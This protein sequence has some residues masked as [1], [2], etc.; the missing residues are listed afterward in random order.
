MQGLHEQ[1]PQFSWNTNAGYPTK[2]HRAAIA[3]HGATVHHR[4]SFRLLSEGRQ[5]TLF[6]G[7]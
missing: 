3:A 5:Y 7:A 4:K 2:A 1:Y 6:D